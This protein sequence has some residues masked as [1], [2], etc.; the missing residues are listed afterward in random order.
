[1]NNKSNEWQS[2]IVE[3]TCAGPYEVD[4]ADNDGR[5]A[6]YWTGSDWRGMSWEHTIVGGTL[7]AAGERARRGMLLEPR[8]V[9]K[10][11]RPLR[12]ERQP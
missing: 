5:C 8:S 12:E 10:R 1:M 4:N 2:W 3:P 7:V 6:A 9:I 11:W